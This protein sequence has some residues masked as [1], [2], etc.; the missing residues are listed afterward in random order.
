MSPSTGVQTEQGVLKTEPKQTDTGGGGL[1][2]KGKQPQELITN[3]HF[4]LEQATE[5]APY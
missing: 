3:G 1:L 5:P 4:H 2:V